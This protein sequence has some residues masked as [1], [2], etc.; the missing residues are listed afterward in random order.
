MFSLAFHLANDT[1]LS[2]IQKSKSN[3]HKKLNKDLMELSFW[4]NANKIAL[5]VATTGVIIFKTKYFT[6][7]KE[8]KLKLYKKELHFSNLISWCQS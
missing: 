7:D 5:N 6:L 4:L 8:V 1:C 2:N 3:I